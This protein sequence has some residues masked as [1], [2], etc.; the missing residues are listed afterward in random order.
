MSVKRGESKRKAKPPPRL[1]SCHR[2]A[3]QPTKKLNLT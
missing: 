2:W 1:R 3:K